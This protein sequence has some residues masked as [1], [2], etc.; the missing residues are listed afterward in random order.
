MGSGLASRDADGRLRSNRRRSEPAHQTVGDVS[1][2]NGGDQ[3][4][5][6]AKPDHKNPEQAEQ[7][8]GR[9]EPAGDSAG[10]R[11]ER[12]S[13]VVGED[14]RR[15]SGL[16]VRREAEVRSLRT[17]GDHHDS[18]KIF[19][20]DFRLTGKLANRPERAQ[21]CCVAAAA[22]NARFKN[23]AVDL[24]T[25]AFYMA[26]DTARVVFLLN[27]KY[28]LTTSWYWKQLFECP[29]QPKD[30]RK[31]V[32]IVAGFVSSNR[33]ELVEAVERLWGETML[34][35]VARGNSIESADIQV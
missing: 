21:R 33:E 26:W 13:D 27:R 22:R 17:P 35:V 24:R 18:Q 16:L 14:L 9:D 25:R 5:H 30:F 4:G 15:S 20:M 6:D 34:P 23:D 11:G 29:V 3:N 32:E 19:A 28:V 10:K 12:D 1:G 7:D 2:H 8:S 31:L